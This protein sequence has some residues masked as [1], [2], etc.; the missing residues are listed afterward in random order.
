MMK[1][2][3]MLRVDSTVSTQGQSRIAEQILEQWE[4]EQGSAQFF[5]S[6]ANFMYIFRKGGER[7]F[8]RFH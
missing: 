6:S 3:T 2:S 1:L 5:R 7:F 4:H 8:L